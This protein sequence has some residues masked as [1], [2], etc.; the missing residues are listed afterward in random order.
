[1]NPWYSE[2][3]RNIR[4]YPETFSEKNKME[5]KNFPLVTSTREYL[6]NHGDLCLYRTC[7]LRTRAGKLSAIIRYN[8]DDSLRVVMEEKY[9]ND[10]QFKTIVAVE[11]IIENDCGNNLYRPNIVSPIRSNNHE[12]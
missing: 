4:N 8:R 5:H 11:R 10:T 9:R 3:W 7:P 1:M 2:T 6:L 12:F